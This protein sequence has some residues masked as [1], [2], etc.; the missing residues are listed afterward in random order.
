MKIKLFVLLSSVYIM[1]QPVS[2]QGDLSGVIEQTWLETRTQIQAVVNSV[3]FPAINLIL[4]IA[5]F[6]KLAGAYFDYK[7]HGM[8]EWQGPAILFVCLVFSLIAPSFIWTI[9]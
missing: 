7:K 5:L 3:V 2:A 9:I 4:V 1:V 8:F 6:V